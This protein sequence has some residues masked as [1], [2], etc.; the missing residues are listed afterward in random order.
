MHQPNPTNSGEQPLSSFSVRGTARPGALRNGPNREALQRPAM[1][2]F[3]RRAD[4]F[5]MVQAKKHAIFGEALSPQLSKEIDAYSARI[6]AASQKE[7]FPY[8]GGASEL[9][10][11][12]ELMPTPL[13]RLLTR[14]S[15]ELASRPE[16][17]KIILAALETTRVEQTAEL[18]AWDDIGKKVKVN[19]SIRQAI[20]LEAQKLMSLNKMAREFESRHSY[21]RLDF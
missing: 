1:T 9:K 20:E 19:D 13:V 11:A 15:A 21:P 3:Q 16:G 6:H 5:D 4:A 18:G 8:R 10:E 12:M 2:L 17:E 14:F 7:G